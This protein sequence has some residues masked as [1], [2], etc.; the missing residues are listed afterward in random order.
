MRADILSTTM[1][2]NGPEGATLLREG[3]K[4]YL[5]TSDGREL[6]LG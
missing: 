1:F 3:E 2:I 4:A 5:I 6:I